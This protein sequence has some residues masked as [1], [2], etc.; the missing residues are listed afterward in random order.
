MVRT[1]ARNGLLAVVALVAGHA[2]AQPPCVDY[3]TLPQT[4]GSLGLHDVC[5]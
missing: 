3:A 5:T 2:I 4:L 1:L